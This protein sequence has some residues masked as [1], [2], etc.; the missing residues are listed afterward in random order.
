MQGSHITSNP[1]PAVASNVQPIDF[2]QLRK[3]DPAL[4]RVLVD[5]ILRQYGERELT[6]ACDRVATEVI[7]GDGKHDAPDTIPPGF[8]LYDYWPNDSFM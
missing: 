3:I 1:Q 4:R 2:D 7:D 8:I 6:I 5:K